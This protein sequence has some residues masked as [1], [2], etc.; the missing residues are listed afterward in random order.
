MTNLLQ[1]ENICIWHCEF[2]RCPAQQTQLKHLLRLR[3]MKNVHP[4]FCQ[5]F[6]PAKLNSLVCALIYA[7]I[8]QNCYLSFYICSNAYLSL[9]PLFKVSLT[10]SENLYIFI[11]PFILGVHY[12]LKLSGNYRLR[13]CYFYLIILQKSLNCKKYFGF[14][15]DYYKNNV[16][17]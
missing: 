7:S 17:N 8:L 11:K 5:K 3:F 9:H 10:A 1:Y 15:C 13:G 2:K 16:K 12:L 6:L 4:P 14:L